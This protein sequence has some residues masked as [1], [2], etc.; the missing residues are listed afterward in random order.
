MKKKHGASARS[1]I[2]AERD[3]RLRAQRKRMRFATAKGTKKR[4][5]SEMPHTYAG[6]MTM[7]AYE[8]ISMAATTA[9]RK[10]DVI[11][12]KTPFLLAVPFDFFRL[13]FAIN[14]IC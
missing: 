1:G 14:N 5:E 12:K 7:D 10:R 11:P 6:L 3:L 13:A 8:R 9:I 2:S 4:P